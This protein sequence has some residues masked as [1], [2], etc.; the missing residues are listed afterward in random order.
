MAGWSFSDIPSQQGRRAVVT[1]TGGLGYETALALARAGAEVTL[2]GRNP[3][4][5]A[6]SVSRIRADVPAARIGFER[7]DLASLASVEDF[8]GRLLA[9]STSLDLLVNNAGVMTPPSRQAT[10]DGFELQFGTN[11]LGHFA[12]TGRLLPLLSK[13]RAPRVVNLSSLAHRGGA[14]HFD[15]LQWERSY[16][17]WAAYGQSKLAM[18]MFAFELQR[19]SDAGGW[20]LMSNAAHPGYARTELIANGPG[21]DRWLFKLTGFIR[22]FAS[23]S[24][25]EGALPTLFAATAPEAR[26]GAYYGPDG[27]YEL[28][29]PPKPAKAMPQAQDRKAAAKLWEVSERLTGVSFPA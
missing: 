17:P 28:K 5:G 29:G 3:E 1:G 14:L 19:R 10:S 22:P 27:F 12:L 18:L 24:A 2:A 20:G 25:A 21:T 13:A 6:D 7:L 8:A 15:D 16:R 11:Y 9:E 4:K 23:Q 26:G